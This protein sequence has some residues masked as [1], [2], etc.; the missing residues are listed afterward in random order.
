MAAVDSQIVMSEDDTLYN[1]GDWWSIR[2]PREGIDL[3]RERV[4]GIDTAVADRWGRISAIG[5]VPGL[6]AATAL[7]GG[8]TLITRDE[9]DV[10][11]L[12]VPVLNP[13]FGR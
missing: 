1:V 12:G 2:A 13:F 6:L 7:A 10:M 11:G 8:L 4:L 5:T 9:R 3:T